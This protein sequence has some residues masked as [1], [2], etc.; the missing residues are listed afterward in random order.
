MHA[1]A[2]ALAL[3]FPKQG[4]LVPFKS[5]GGI[6]LGMTPAQVTAAWGTKHGRCH[7]CP[8]ATWYFTYRPFT[9]TGAGVSFKAGHV[10]AVFTL[11][12]PLGWHEGTLAI[13]DDKQS[14]LT[15]FPT[16]I[17]VPCSNYDAYIVTHAGVTT[18][19]YVFGGKLWGFALTPSNAPACR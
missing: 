12:S 1:L 11:W 14:L 2:L 3:L 7:G 17:R 18:A 4:T 15:D 5:L 16:A 13:G 10:D 6:R 9:P 8:E 19:F